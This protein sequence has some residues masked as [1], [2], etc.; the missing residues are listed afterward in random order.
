MD[1]NIKNYQEEDI[2]SKCDEA[3]F[4]KNQNFD[5]SVKEVNNNSSGKLNSY[6]N[7]FNNLINIHKWVYSVNNYNY[8]S[9]CFF[10]I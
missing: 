1:N 9:I 6:M 2:K 10:R 4:E 3:F 7:I 8:L 5:S